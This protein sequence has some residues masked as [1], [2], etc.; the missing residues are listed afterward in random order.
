MKIAIP[1]EHEQILQRL[2]TAI[3]QTAA[4][5]HFERLLSQFVKEETLP[6]KV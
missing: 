3:I 1:P 4:F 2:I 5:Y 6:Q